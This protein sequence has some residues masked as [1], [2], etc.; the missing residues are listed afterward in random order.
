LCE[1]L[2]ALLERSAGVACAALGLPDFWKLLLLL[3]FCEGL[4]V[5]RVRR[6]RAGGVVCV[7]LGVWVVLCVEFWVDL[8]CGC[9]EAFSGSV[10]RRMESLMNTLVSSMGCLACRRRCHRHQLSQMKTM[11]S[12]TKMMTSRM[13]KTQKRGQRNRLS[14][15]TSAKEF[16]Q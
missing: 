16:Y 10:G 9:W 1:A 3:W 12:L 6:E 2:L 11:M 13:K 8:E 5:L 14:W 15:A 4:V 7:E